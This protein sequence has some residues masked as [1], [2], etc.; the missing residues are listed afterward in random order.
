MSLWSV[1]L[2]PLG[3]ANSGTGASEG[4]VSPSFLKLPLRVSLLFRVEE[5]LT[6]KNRTQEKNAHLLLS[7]GYFIG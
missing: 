6:L 1:A 7:F 4:E 3:S 2:L 5:S